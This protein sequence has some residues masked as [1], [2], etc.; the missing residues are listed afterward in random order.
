MVE[1]A[2]AWG[3]TIEAHHE[4]WQGDLALMRIVAANMRRWRKEG[5]THLL[6]LDAFDMVMI[7]PPSELETKLAIYGSPPLLC[8]AE[9]GCWPGD[10]R[11]EEYG[12]REHQWHYAHSPL[13]F[14]L[15]QETPERYWQMKDRGYGTDQF[16][17][18]DLVIDGVIPIDRG[19]HIVM[20]MAHV[21]PWTDAFDIVGDRVH[22]RIT[23]GTGLV[24]HGNGRT[25]LS[26][27]PMKGS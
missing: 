16:H 27:V 4:P 19:Q 25:D 24:A 13:T 14:D 23:G 3:W 6:R 22:N 5:Y 8:S 20:S 15:R 12:P 7:G 2:H 1:S 21:N 18:A 26:W 17:L 10:Y 9:A 11:K